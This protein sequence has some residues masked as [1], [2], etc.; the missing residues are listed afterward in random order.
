M[1]KKV[2]KYKY[3]KKYFIPLLVLVI[4]GLVFFLISKIPLE[5][6]ISYEVPEVP[7]APE[8]SEIPEI[9]EEE[10]GYYTATF[11][12][13]FSGQAWLDTEKTSLYFDWTS[14]NLLFPPVIETEEL[15]GPDFLDNFIPEK[16][17]AS[18]NLVLFSG[19]HRLSKKRQILLWDQGENKWSKFDF[20][21][22]GFDEREGPLAVFSGRWPHEWFIF[23]RQGPNIQANFLR[24]IN[25]SPQPIK[26]PAKSI[27]SLQEAQ[28][29]C[30]FKECLI[31]IPEAGF[32]R[33][34]PDTGFQ[35]LEILLRR[36][37]EKSPDEIFIFKDR[38]P[39]TY[40]LAWSK[41]KDDFYEF[42]V[43]GIEIMGDEPIIK[44]ILAEGQTRGRY[45]G[46]PALLRLENGN[47]FLF[48]GSYW[49]QAYEISPTGG[50]RDLTESF[51]WRISAAKT[52][53]LYNFPHSIYIKNEDR[54]V[55]RW[56]DETNVRIDPKFWLTF[57]PSFL[58]IIPLTLT[59][60]VNERD[61]GYL[62]AGV[63]A[64]GTKIFEF[65]DSGF[66][67]SQIRQAV[68]QK[69]NFSVPAIMAAEISSLQ[70]EAKNAKIECW[71]SNDA[72]VNW[73]KA[74]V[75]QKIAFK[76]RGNDLRWRIRIIPE[77][78]CFSYITP[79][80]RSIHLQYWYER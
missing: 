79:Y 77:T 20:A 10:A 74:E 51:G 8:V 48:W 3:K 16:V 52:F 64:G 78:S 24:I 28:I 53:H 61:T 41:K 46:R 80:L 75:G 63:P 73:T 1:K 35:K 44:V 38:D 49:T 13:S 47:I 76:T 37:Q 18:Q 21:R 22:L 42:S 2:K 12:D 33:F 68:S 11:S 14:T 7:E 17:S 65:T 36:L 40:L 25:G 26:G 32:F 27:G 23:S 30:S 60:N 70:G 57:N 59:S 19:I 66:D 43:W 31:Y 55:I 5:P 58:E 45:P 39:G 54:S 29:E 50:L 6:E 9:P 62:I 56:N 34:L 15:L 67:L 72:G 71:L 69:V 4:A